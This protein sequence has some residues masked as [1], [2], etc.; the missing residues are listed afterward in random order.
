MSARK[1]DVLP[2]VLAVI[3]LCVFAAGAVLLLRDAPAAESEAET[4]TAA[5]AAETTTAQHTE[6]TTTLTTA[7]QSVTSAAE[8]TTAPPETEPETDEERY[9]QYVQETLLPKYGKAAEGIAAPDAQTGIAAAYICDFLG[10]GTDMLVIRLDALDGVNAAVPVLL[11]Y[12]LYE[13]KVVLAD[14][15]ESKLPLSGY[16][17]RYAGQTLYISGEHADESLSP[18][19]LLC[20]EITVMM[21]DNR[22]MIL[23]DLEQGSADDIPAARYPEDAALLLELMPDTAAEGGRRYLL[24]DHT[25]FHS[26]HGES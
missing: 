25:D 3:L 9:L 22:D 16:C 11:W 7:V 21:Q 18:E 1:S 10:K 20:T 15:F 13:G 24:Y 19:S 26:T 8:T 23:T 2:A 14:T 4:E 5:A 6:Q 17:I 12:T